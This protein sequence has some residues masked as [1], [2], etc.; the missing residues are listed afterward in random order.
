MW[1]TPRDITHAAP[2][3]VLTRTEMLFYSWTH[4]EREAIALARVATLP[5]DA[6]YQV[7]EDTAIRCFCAA[8][9][10]AGLKDSVEYVGGRLVNRWK[11]R[12][13]DC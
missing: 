9:E 6:S 10:H 12:D 4:D 7:I 1:I 5:E 13:N 11:E 8:L 2:L 3:R